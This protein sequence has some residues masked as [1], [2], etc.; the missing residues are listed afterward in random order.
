VWDLSPY[1]SR[2]LKF[3]VGTNLRIRRAFRKQGVQPFVV[4]INVIEKVNCTV[5]LRDGGH[6]EN[7]NLNHGPW[8]G[9]N[10]RWTQAKTIARLT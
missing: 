10:Q 9:H 8:H 2:G 3:W 6:V 4:T 5:L 7:E 1:L